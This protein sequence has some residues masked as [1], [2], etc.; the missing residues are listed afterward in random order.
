M[1]V[2]DGDAT[3]FEADDAVVGDGDAEDVTGEIVSNGLQ[4]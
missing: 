1:L 3:I 2:A 4:S